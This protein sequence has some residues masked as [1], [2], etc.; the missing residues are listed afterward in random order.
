MTLTHPIKFK[1]ILAAL[2]L[3]AAAASSEAAVITADFSDNPFTVTQVNTY[4]SINVNAGTA[5]YGFDG[6]SQFVM[7]FQNSEDSQPFLWTMSMGQGVMMDG[8]YTAKMAAGELVDPDA[9]YG[10]GPYMASGELGNWAEGGR[11][12]VGFRVDNG[13]GG[14]NYGYADVS[15]DPSGSL[16]L[17]GFSY[18]NNGGSISTSAVPEPSSILLSGAGI[19]ALLLRRRRRA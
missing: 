12:F 11:G 7:A 5:S 1:A 10:Y 17:H 9:Q 19:T 14:F 8:A 4:I 18:E 2:G 6:W 15:Y 13:T 3:A 16:S